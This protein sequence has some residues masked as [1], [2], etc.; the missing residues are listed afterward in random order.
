MH[1]TLNVSPPAANPP[2]RLTD[3]ELGDNLLLVLLAGHDTSSTTL[4]HVLAELQRHPRVMHALRQEQEA[5]V[6]RHGPAITPAALRD[7]GYA[8]AVVR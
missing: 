2:A 7:M 4:T 5:V 1:P 6:A 8:E 3:A